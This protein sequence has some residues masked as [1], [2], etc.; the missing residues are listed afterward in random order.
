MPPQPK[1]PAPPPNSQEPRTRKG[2]RK[3][4]DGTEHP[5]TGRKKRKTKGKDRARVDDSEEEV[6]ISSDND[7]DDVIPDSA[8]AREGS[9]RS[10]RARKLVAGGYTEDDLENAE[11]PN[12]GADEDIEM[13]ADTSLEPSEPYNNQVQ[14]GEPVVKEEDDQDVTLTEPSLGTNYLT[15]KMSSFKYGDRFRH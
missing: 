1:Q 11:D 6:D 7:S 15:L 3:T 4:N 5:G 2:K 13:V 10:G 14:I 12:L 9:R 8:C